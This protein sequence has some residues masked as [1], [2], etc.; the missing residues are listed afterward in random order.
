M[1]VLVTE[2]DPVGLITPS[3]GIGQLSLG[4]LSRDVG[5]LWD[6]AVGFSDDDDDI[7]HDWADLLVVESYVWWSRRI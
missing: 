5:L 2:D 7:E 6:G 1:L 3:L 4:L